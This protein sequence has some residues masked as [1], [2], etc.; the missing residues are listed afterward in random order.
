MLALPLDVRLTADYTYTLEGTETVQSRACYVVAFEPRS[1]ICRSTVG[2]SGFDR[3]RFV[4]LKLQ[5]V[6]T[7]LAA[8]FV[9]SEEIQSFTPVSDAA[10]REFVLFSTLTARQIVLIAGSQPA[11][12]KRR[13]LLRTFA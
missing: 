1:R 12:G 3:E 4:R 9:S 10:G 13:A 2:V 6:Q 7:R 5:T 8:P 11:A